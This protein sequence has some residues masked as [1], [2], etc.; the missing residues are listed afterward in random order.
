MRVHQLAGCVKPR[1]H[2][3]EVTVFDEMQ[4]QA[5]CHTMD[6]EERRLSTLTE[7]RS[8]IQPRQLTLARR[9]QSSGRDRRSRRRAVSDHRD[10]S[11][12]SSSSSV[13]LPSRDK[14]QTPTTDDSKRRTA[15]RSS[16][17]TFHEGRLQE[18]ATG[19]KR[20]RR[21]GVANSES[22]QDVKTAEH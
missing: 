12:S 15:R 22:L 14:E 2:Q 9:D 13:K 17:E 5:P 20:R 11:P 7:L 18:Y 16:L 10:S 4:R 21:D 19:N 3:T 1:Q 6:H 8:H